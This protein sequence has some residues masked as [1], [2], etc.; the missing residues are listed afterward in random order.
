VVRP[1]ARRRLVETKNPS[2]CAT[3]NVKRVEIAIAL[4]VSVTTNGCNRSANKIQS[5]EV[6]PAH[7][8]D[9]YHPTRHNT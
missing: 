7:F 3:V 9:V 6:E 4:Y 5:F 1:V 2:A 8:R